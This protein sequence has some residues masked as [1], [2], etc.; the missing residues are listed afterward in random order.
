MLSERIA[1]V[2]LST[3]PFDFD[4]ASPLVTLPRYQTAEIQVKTT[5]IAGF[6]C[7]IQFV[8]RGSELDQNQL[9]K[10]RVRLHMGQAT[11]ENAT[12]TAPL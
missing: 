6:E 11:A 2:L 5:R 1:V 12:L 4:L 3:S 10:P 7:P 9:R 8:A